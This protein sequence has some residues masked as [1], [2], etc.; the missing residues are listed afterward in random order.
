MPMTPPPIETVPHRDAGRVERVMWRRR[1]R[2]T[3][4][5]LAIWFIVTFGVSF[6]ARELSIVVAGWPVSFWMASQGALLVYVALVVFYARRMGR[7]DEERHA[8]LGD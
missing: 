1:M 5:L 2:I 8:A 7:L 4:W 3:G 6:F